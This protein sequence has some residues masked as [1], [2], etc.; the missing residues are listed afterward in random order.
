MSAG[1]FFMAK[2][3]GRLHPCINYRGLNEITTKYRQPLPLVLAAIEQLHVARFFYQVGP[4]ECIHPHLM[5]GHYK[6]LVMPFVLTNVPSVFQAFVNELFRDMLGCQ[7]VV[8]INDILIYSPTLED[9]I[10]HI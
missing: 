5:S 10:G 4:A 7:V 9:H 2:K 6:Y 3:D 8:Y 1:F